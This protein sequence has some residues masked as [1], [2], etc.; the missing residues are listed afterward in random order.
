MITKDENTHLSHFPLPF[1]G[2]ESRRYKPGRLL[3]K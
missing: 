2:E 1:A 3:T